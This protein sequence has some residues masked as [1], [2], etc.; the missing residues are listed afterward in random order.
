MGQLDEK[1]S[2]Y[3][4][5]KLAENILILDRELGVEKSYDVIRRDIIIAG[6][7]AA[8]YFIDGFAKDD[9]MLW[10]MQTLSTVEKEDISI[11]PLEKLKTRFINYIET[12]L[13]DQ[14]DQI[15]TSVLSGSV[16]LLIDGIEQGII[17]DAREYPARGP[18]EPDI[19]R[20]S[21][22]SRDGFV[23]TLVFNSSLV[24]R[25]IRDP[26]LRMELL[27][28]G[29]RSKTDVIISY[30][31]DIANPDLVNQI[32]DK[33]QSINIDGLPMAE[34]S[35]EELIVPG[36]YWNPFPRVRYTERPDVSAVHLLEGHILL[37]VDTSPSVIILPT[38]FF[39]HVQ[40]AEEYRQNPS[41][42]VYLR[43]V[44]FLGIISSILILPLWYLVSVQPE[45]LPEGLKYIGPEK[46]GNVPLFFQIILVEIGIDL[47]RMAAIH[48]PS[49]LATALG[50]IAAFL[51]GDVAINIG[52][53][54]P[55]VILYG[56]LAAVGT[57]ATPSFELGLANRFIRLFLLFSSALL[58]LP[59]FMGGIAIVFIF[60][61]FMKSFGIPYLWP[62]IPLDWRALKSIIVRSPVPIQNIRPEILAPLDKTRQKGG[63]IPTPARK[64]RL[65]WKKNK[66]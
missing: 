38:T 64:P 13:T 47:I 53:F 52:L 19:E 25:R 59:G 32:K 54:A 43:W 26:K 61:A 1:Q 17:I 44:R 11:D 56:A 42:G 41:I 57:F 37:I 55:E 58:G 31:E 28:V 62:L 33:L 39:H 65:K 9:I 12:D 49:P 20:V 5:K 22:G 40:H 36:S 10:I 29:R 45:L 15:I 18:E 66:E 16:V 21:R 4:N 23:E 7:K 14:L 3:V 60:L 24:R 48:T 50:L 34:K 46:F 2:V 51:I 63:T 8:L 6:K 30:I 35:I 27:Q